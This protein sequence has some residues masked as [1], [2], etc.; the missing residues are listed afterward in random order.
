M[1]VPVAGDGEVTI[2]VGPLNVFPLR[3]GPV[4][5]LAEAAGVWTTARGG[6]AVAWATGAA[7]ARAAIAAVARAARLRTELGRRCVGCVDIGSPE[8]E[9]FLAGRWV[10]MGVPY[11]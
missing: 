3:I 10:S 5:E 7:I 4:T 1:T 9:T 11:L 8:V 6:A 2:T